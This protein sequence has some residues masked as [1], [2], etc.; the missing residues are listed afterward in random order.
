MKFILKGFYNYFFT[1]LL[2]NLPL[3]F[4]LLLNWL[5]F[6]PLNLKRIANQNC[7]KLLLPGTAQG[8]FLLW[9]TYLYPTLLLRNSPMILPGQLGPKTRVPL[10]V[11]LSADYPASSSLGSNFLP[12][13]ESLS[14]PR[15]TVLIL[16]LW[17]S[18]EEEKCSLQFH[19][20]K[21]WE[22]KPKHQQDHILICLLPASHLYW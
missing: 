22:A 16:M 7:R 12:M 4:L 18:I 8:F 9:F 21:A 14:W 19:T 1:P 3:G 5:S 10:D 17:G 6:V 2:N 15:S 11:S 20:P 13:D